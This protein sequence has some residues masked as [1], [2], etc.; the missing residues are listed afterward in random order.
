VIA[1]V[2][3]N[4]TADWVARFTSASS[5]A[6]LERAEAAGIDRQAVR[7]QRAVTRDTIKAMVTLLTANVDPNDTAERVRVRDEFLTKIRAADS[8]LAEID[9]LDG[10]AE[11]QRRE[12]PLPPQP[13]C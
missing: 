9:R 11:Q 12:N 3:T 5:A 4:N 2:Q 13:R 1:L 8:Q 10:A 6:Q 7:Q